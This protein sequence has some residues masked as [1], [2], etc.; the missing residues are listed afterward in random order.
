MQSVTEARLENALEKEKKYT[1]WITFLILVIIVL[2]LF[3]WWQYDQSQKKIVPKSTR[4]EVICNIARMDDIS[5]F[6]NGNHIFDEA[7]YMVFRDKM[8]GAEIREDMSAKN[9][10][11]SM[12][13]RYGTTNI[14]EWPGF[15]E[16]CRKAWAEHKAMIKVERE[17]NDRDG[18]SRLP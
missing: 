11:Q 3:N 16:R 6:S 2:G 4:L 7:M 13:D 15:D 10:Y 5:M 12:V 8:L 1:G 17:A 9:P 18:T 14:D